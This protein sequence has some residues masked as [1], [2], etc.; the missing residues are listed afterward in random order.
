MN[1][2][3]VSSLLLGASI[4]LVSAETIAK[5]VA[6]K[7]EKGATSMPSAR[8]IEAKMMDTQPINMDQGKEAVMRQL[9]PMMSQMTTG[10]PKIDAELQALSKETES[11]IRAIQEDYMKKVKK[12]VEGHTL[13]RVHTNQ[14]SEPNDVEQK[15]RPISAVEMKEK[16]NGMRARAGDE[17]SSGRPQGGYGLMQSSAKSPQDEKK[18]VGGFKFSNP[19]EGMFNR[20]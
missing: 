2:I 15:G 10:D 7:T 18:E 13:T 9:A 14:K 1:K 12:L 8:L 3:L 17:N 5:P 16:M 20:E 6:G 11:K 4:T 19:F